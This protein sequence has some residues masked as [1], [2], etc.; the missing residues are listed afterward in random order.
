[1]NEYDIVKAFENIEDILITS[2]KRNLSKHLVDEKLEDMNWTMWQ[3]EQLKRLQEY[4]KRH[5]KLFKGKYTNINKSIETLLKNKFEN[6]QL[7]QEKLILNNI[8]NNKLTTNSKQYY[9]NMSIFRSTKSKRIKKKTL[10]NLQNINRSNSTFFKINER[11][12]DSLIKATTNDFEKAENSIL[13]YTNDKYRKIIFNAQV[14]ANTGAGTPEQ[15]VDMATKDFLSRGIN[16]IEYTNGAMVNI[17]SYANMAIRTASLR[18]YAQG[19]GE[20]RAEWGI[21][22]VCVPKRGGGCPKCVLCQG[23]VYVDD[24]YSGGSAKEAELLGYPLLSKAMEKGFMH[25]GCKDGVVTY[26]PEISTPIKPPTLE[27][28]E[29]KKKTYM[30]NQKLSNAKYQIRKYDRL[31]K[32]SIDKEKIAEYENKHKQW[33]EYEIKLKNSI[34][35]DKIYKNE[36]ILLSEKEKEALRNYTGFEA[37]KINK[38]IRINKITNDIQNK[39]NI[40]DSAISKAISLK[41]DITLYRGGIVQNFVGFENIRNVSHE[42]IMN[43]SE[44]VITDTAYISTSKFKAEEQGRNIIMK[45]KVPKGFKG[46][47]DIKEYAVNKYKY[48]NEVLL[49]KNTSFFVNKIDY[50]EGKYYF[51]MEVIV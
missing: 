7:E 38:A 47:L 34:K 46:A 5:Q 42:T 39:I 43:L 14:Y 18:A 22:T 15:A 36:K 44:K 35:N 17:A 27:E 37:T 16:N 11:K 28:I 41:E 45:I 12:L 50:R 9:K 26:F 24:V 13:R 10:N 30:Q 23:K 33:V 25:P 3:S 31:K 8:Q 21:H 19:E 2:M 1:M 32:G 4:K 6:G 48:Q 20:K 40:L 51:D 29:E 49:K